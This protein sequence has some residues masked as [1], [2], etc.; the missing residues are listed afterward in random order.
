MGNLH[1]VLFFN[2][3]DVCKEFSSW[4]SNLR[5]WKSFDAKGFTSMV[6]II[7]DESPENPRTEWDNA[8][9]I[10]SLSDRS[11]AS[12]KGASPLKVSVKERDFSGCFY[13]DM[14][15]VDGSH[16]SNCKEVSF[17]YVS[18]SREKV[19]VLPIYMYSH[20]GDTIKNTPF[21]CRW[22]SGLVGY[23]YMTAST[24]LEMGFGKNGRV[25]WKRVKEVLQGETETYNSYITGDIYGFQKFD[26]NPLNGE[27][28]EDESD[29]CWGFYGSDEKENGMMDHWNLVKCDDTMIFDLCEA[30]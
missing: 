21:G 2:G 28:E 5:S 11:F 23:I 10:V 26:I 12:D 1:K 25:N 4:D 3:N 29:S 6:K 24:A 19:C 13:Y 20:S 8:G 17:F 14:E 15:E 16:I 27:I 18:G 22:D 7:N 9:T 30:S